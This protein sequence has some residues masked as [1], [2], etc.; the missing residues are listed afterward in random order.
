MLA[1]S[2]GCIGDTEA[3]QLKVSHR[4]GGGKSAYCNTI[5]RARATESGIPTCSASNRVALYDAPYTR[6]RDL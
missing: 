5:V 3:D 6:P 2:S 1:W 4:T